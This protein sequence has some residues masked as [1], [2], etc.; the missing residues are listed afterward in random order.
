VAFFTANLSTMIL[1]LIGAK[2][3]ETNW[4]NAFVVYGIAL[5]VLVFTM[6]FIPDREKERVSGEFKL[7]YF[8]RTVILSTLGYLFITMLFLSQPSNISIFVESEHYG[9]AATVAGISAAS[10]FVTMILNL[11]FSKI[12]T[13]LKDSVF[14]LGLLFFGFGFA[15]I[16]FSRNLAMVIAG[17]IMIGA[18]M[19]M[20]HP[21]WSFKATQNTPRE[22]ATS[23]LSLVNSGFRMGTFTSPV[24]FLLVDSAFRVSTI[25][26]EFLLASAISVAAMA[27]FLVW[28]GR[29]RVRAREKAV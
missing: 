4:R 1:P 28:S 25:R 17:Y 14:P 5:L 27:A 29:S 16:S 15:T 24:F 9:N 2:L 8:S 10:T 12:Y 19:G 26:G 23:A 21:F 3:D 11:N 13:K 18:T 22:Y 7:F 6:L 20:L